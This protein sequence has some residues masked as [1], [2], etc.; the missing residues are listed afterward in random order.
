MKK[1]EDLRLVFVAFMV[2][3]FCLT[4]LMGPLW[5]LRQNVD[6]NNLLGMMGIAGLY[7]LLFNFNRKL[8]LFRV[9]LLSLSAATLITYLDQAMGFSPG[10]YPIT[11]FI[12]LVGFMLGLFSFIEENFFVCFV[13]SV[14]WG[15][16]LDLILFKADP[17]WLWY[18]DKYFI[19]I[20]PSYLIL[21]LSLSVI[22]FKGLASRIAQTA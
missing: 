10:L 19:Y 3:T 12:G 2:T 8:S 5:F 21:A 16:A 22:R 7:S 14:M 15:I 18:V 6:T 17:W 4:L 13:S 1:S 11:M 20:V 9:V